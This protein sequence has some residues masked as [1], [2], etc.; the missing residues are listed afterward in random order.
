M[1]LFGFCEKC[2]LKYKYSC[3]PADQLEEIYAKY[4]SEA[5]ISLEAHSSGFTKLFDEAYEKRMGRL[6][7]SRKKGK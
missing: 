2:G 5:T 3:I 4:E 7:E 1:R 6:V